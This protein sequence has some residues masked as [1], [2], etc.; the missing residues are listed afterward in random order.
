MKNT[1]LFQIW[2]PEITDF[3]SNRGLEITGFGSSRPLRSPISDPLLR[4]PI[5][6]PFCQLEITHFGSSFEITHFGS[7]LLDP[8]RVISE[9]Q[10]EPERA[11]LGKKETEGVGAVVR[12][13][14]S[15][16]VAVLKGL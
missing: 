8:K 11:I 14:T 10:L 13:L 16:L 1:H 7:S 15:I 5:S 12:R 6:D 3:R 4:S 9:V 2:G